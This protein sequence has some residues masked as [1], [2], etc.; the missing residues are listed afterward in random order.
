MA[1]RS[2][3]SGGG[4]VNLWL[5]IDA[6]AGVGR[7]ALGFALAMLALALPCLAFALL[8]EWLQRVIEKVWKAIGVVLK[9]TLALCLI[10]FALIALSVLVT[11]PGAWAVF[12]A[13]GAGGAIARR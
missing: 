7:Y 10:P 12:L 4:G 1:W 2:S 13:L 6:A 9:C 3:R 11:V 5:L 8:P